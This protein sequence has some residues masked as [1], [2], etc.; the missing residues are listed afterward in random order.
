[1][2]LIYDNFYPFLLHSVLPSLLNLNS[3]HLMVDNNIIMVHVDLT[4]E[5]APTPFPLVPISQWTHES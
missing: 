2:K 4:V 1:M 5:R 3:T